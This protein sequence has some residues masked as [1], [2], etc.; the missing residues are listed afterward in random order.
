[1]DNGYGK[2]TNI[3]INFQSRNI[4][5]KHIAINFYINQHSFINSLLI[6]I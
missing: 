3:N 2:E 4:V 1:M 6:C 5:F